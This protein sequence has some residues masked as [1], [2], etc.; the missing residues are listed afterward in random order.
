[1]DVGHSEYWSA[2]QAAA[3]VAARERGTSLLFLSSDTLAWR[4]RYGRAGSR[5][6]AAGA[7]AHRIVA[8][9]QFVSGDPDRADPSGLYPFGGARLAGSAYDGCITPRVRQPGPPVYRLDSWRPNPALQPAWLFERSGVSVSTAI[10]GIVGYELDERTSASPPNTVVV[11]GS[12]PVSCQAQDEPSP[13][14]GDAAQ[15]TL[16]TARSGAIVF[17]S[18]TLAWLYGLS[19]VPQASP[20]A[21]RTPDPRVVAMT[22][23]LLARA[24]RG[25]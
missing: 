5:S 15:T 17:A 16:Y 23:N 1:M 13:A 6:S 12:G 3:L 24:L 4:I 9:K 20:D 14:K 7:P 18:G 22:R 21:P 2:R 25:D 8:Y 10:A 11:G 19:P